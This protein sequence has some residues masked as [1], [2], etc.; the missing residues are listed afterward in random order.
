M[1]LK[2]GNKKLHIAVITA[3]LFTMISSCSKEQL[4]SIKV[5][6]NFAGA[7]WVV[8]HNIATSGQIDDLLKTAKQSG[9]KNIFVQVRGRGDAYYTSSIEP[10]AF[11]VP[12]SFD[13]LNYL[14]E[15]GVF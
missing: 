15:L 10:S 3:I 4:K 7:L 13:P 1:T 9:I 11:D 12:E 14:F 2:Y 8:R 5:K 6:R